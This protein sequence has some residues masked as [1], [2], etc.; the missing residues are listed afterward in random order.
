MFPLS[1]RDNK[2]SCYNALIYLSCRNLWRLI[3]NWG[4][5]FKIFVGSESNG[6][7]LSH[8]S[9]LGTASVPIFHQI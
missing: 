2:H 9:V 3:F 4:V 5:F 8:F 1:L 7:K 6:L